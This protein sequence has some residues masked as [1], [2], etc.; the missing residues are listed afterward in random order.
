MKY[1]L[2]TNLDPVLLSFIETS[3]HASRDQITEVF[4][5][6]PFGT[7]GASRDPF[8]VGNVS[9]EGIQKH[10]AAARE[11]GIKVNYLF[12]SY[13]APQDRARASKDIAAVI[14]KVQPDIVTVAHD[15][16]LELLRG[17]HPD[18]PVCISIVRGVRDAEEIKRLAGKYTIKRIIPHQS[19]VRNWDQ[20]PRIIAAA[21]EAG[22]EIELLAN[23]MCQY[24]CPIMRDHYRTLS[25]ASQQGK[26]PSDRHEKFCNQARAENPLDFINATWIRPEDVALYEEMGVRMLKLAGRDKPT[27]YLTKVARAFLERGYDGNVMDLFSTTW[28]PEQKPPYVDNRQLDGLVRGMRDMGITHF[29][30]MSAVPGQNRIKYYKTRLR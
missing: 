25:R 16:F 3:N 17:N 6:I 21:R 26:K 11:A 4:A 8:R 5:A 10:F 14:E 12:N 13:L 15:S 9:L 22:V 2:G 24:E 18:I 7:A 28:W 19:T 27:T 1:T 20:L 23:E 30:E 29:E